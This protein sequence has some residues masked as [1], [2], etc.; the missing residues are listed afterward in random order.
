[1][2]LYEWL[3]KA[4]EDPTSFLA[5]AVTVGIAVT[6]FL[7]FMILRALYDF[8]GGRKARL[9]HGM[10]RD[11]LWY[12][13]Y[14]N[15]WKTKDGKGKN[16]YKYTDEPGIYIILFFRHK[17]LRSRFKGYE[18]VYVGQSLTAHKRLF[19]HLSGFGNGKIY[20]EIKDG[21]KAYVKIVPCSKK[22]LNAYEKTFI[23]LYG[24]ERS[25]N[26]TK[27]GAAKR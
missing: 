12:E 27:G 18:E 14:M 9:R 17:V 21:K 8:F 20:H 25:F 6:L 7:A 4:Y 26:A 11:F 5:L 2:K 22:D 3:M 24:A 23:E 1:M 19:Q 13:T 16:G 10:Y 15:E